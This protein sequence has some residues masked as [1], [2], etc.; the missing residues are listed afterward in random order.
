LKKCSNDNEKL[1]T[2][3]QKIGAAE[4][5]I[6]ELDDSSFEIIQLDEQEGKNKEK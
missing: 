5:R 3:N 4:K 1:T 2:G 6:I